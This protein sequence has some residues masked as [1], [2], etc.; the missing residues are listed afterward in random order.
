MMQIFHILRQ[1]RDHWA[2]GG[3]ASAVRLLM[4]QLAGG[5]R[6][7]PVRLRHIDVRVRSGTPDL[8]VALDCLH[9]GEFSDI[10]RLAGSAEV[11]VDAGGYIGTSAI[12]LAQACPEARIIVLEPSADNYA[13][14]CQ[15]V[16]RWPTITP[17]NAALSDRDGRAVLYDRGSGEWGF[18]M[19]AGPSQNNSL[20]E[21]DMISLPTLMH[22]FSI[23]GIDVLKLDIEGGEK[24]VLEAAD[25]WRDHVGLIVA[26]LHD[27]VVAGCSEAFQQATEGWDVIAFR[28]EK[29][30]RQ[31]PHHRI[32]EP[33]DH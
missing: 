3:G 1:F 7:I 12:A 18:T 24:A 15:N 8:N 28:G 9:F 5:K 22:R 21:I 23:T 31:N 17:V 6:L 14:L 29:Q 25:Q 27:R 32:T 26:E 13:V 20:G 4:H 30:A 10:S 33:K 2:A 16:A 19:V 11:I